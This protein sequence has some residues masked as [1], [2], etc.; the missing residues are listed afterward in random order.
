MP[1]LVDVIVVGSGAAGA[2]AA[3]HLAARGRRVILLERQSLPRPK[4]WGGGMAASVGAAAA[5]E[6]AEPE[7]RARE[8]EPWAATA[9]APPQGNSWKASATA[10][11]SNRLEGANRQRPDRT[12]ADQ[13]DTGFARQRLNGCGE[14][15][16]D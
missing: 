10:R 2:S 1:D 7:S 6:L 11:M 16:G 13:C 9:S 14:K 5:T 8:A 12:S 15:V 4:P 3:F